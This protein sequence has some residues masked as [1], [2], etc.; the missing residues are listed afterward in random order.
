MNGEE[1]HR[2]QQNLVETLKK[3]NNITTPF[4]EKAFRRVPRH[5]FLPDEP[6]EKVY[7][8]VAIAVRRDAQGQWT[9]SSSQPAIMAI[10]L[11]QLDLQPGQRVLEIGTGSGYNAALMASVVGPQGRVVTIDIQP[12]LVEQARKSLQVAGY[13]QVQVIAGDGGFGYPE[14]APYDRIILTVASSVITPAWRQQLA[15][16]GRLVLPFSMI[17]GQ[18]S[19]AFE[20]RGEEL[21]SVSIKGC[22]FML[23][24]GAFAPPQPARTQIG[25]DPRLFLLHFSGQDLP[26]EA[27]RFAGWLNEEG[28]DW[29][30]G[31][32]T[33]FAELHD[34][35][36]P[37]ITVRDLQVP[38]GTGLAAG[39]CATGDL[40]DKNLIPALFGR[41][42][43]WKQM[44]TFVW[45]EPGGAA[46][47]TR[48]PGVI[49]PLVDPNH[50]FDDE[51]FELYIRQLGPSTSATER[52]LK[53]IQYWDRAGK[54]SSSRWHIRAIAAEKE[55]HP[56]EGEY[57]LERPYT[58]L[59]IHY[60]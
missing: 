27:E 57:L 56:A 49:P 6:L 41:G 29:S 25:P 35:F 47:I 60:L 7:S 52:L 36:F 12:D 31:M 58:K 44:N 3:D 8:D 54:P 42:G 37:W 13:D 22:G 32:T 14:G 20:R 9:S 2:L 16:G 5:L 53:H 46:A 45:I 39:L 59:V 11:E 43:E 38:G 33:A 15:P 40:A 1:I 55:Y 17:T 23:L 50:P 48:P 26:L 18:Q 28:K 24:Q 51:P 4:I 10:M 21:V 34:S 19:V 30:T